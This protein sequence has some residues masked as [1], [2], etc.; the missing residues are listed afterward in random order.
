PAPVQRAGRARARSDRRNPSLTDA[1]RRS[2]AA[3]RLFQ[4]GL[5]GVDRDLQRRVGVI[6]PQFAP[7][8][9]Y[10][11]QPLRVLAGAERIAVGKNVETD[12]ALD[13]ADTAAHVARQPRVRAG[14]DVPGAHAVAGLEAGLRSEE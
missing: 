3:S 12:H 6:A 13:R 11:I 1:G 5:P 2:G 4:I 10:A 7:V 9:P 8:E 14:M